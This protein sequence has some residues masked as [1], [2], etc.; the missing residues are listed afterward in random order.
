MPDGVLPSLF[1]L[2]VVREVSHDVLVDSVEGQPLLGT[3]SDGHHD[4]RVVAV[5]RLLV[6]LLL[7]GFVFL[8]H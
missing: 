2:A 8:V 7:L 3:L 4:Q 6:L 1:V 5:G